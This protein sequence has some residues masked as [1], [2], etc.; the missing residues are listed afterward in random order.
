MIDMSSLGTSREMVLASSIPVYK[1]PPV[2]PEFERKPSLVTR[3]CSWACCFF[4]KFVSHVP[5]A[6]RTPPHRFVAVPVARGFLS[7]SIGADINGVV[8]MLHQQNYFTGSPSV[9]KKRIEELLVSEGTA[10]G[11]VLS[12]LVY[13]RTPPKS[14]EDEIR[15]ISLLSA[16]E[17]VKRCGEHEVYEVENKE[18]ATQESMDRFLA[19][20][21]RAL[22]LGYNDFR[23]QG[24]G[25]NLQAMAALFKESGLECERQALLLDR[26]E[27]EKRRIAEGYEKLTEAVTRYETTYF[28]KEAHVEIERLQRLLKSQTDI[29]S[30][31]VQTTEPLYFRFLI[32]KKGVVKESFSAFVEESRSFIYVPKKGKF[33]FYKKQGCY[34][35]IQKL[36]A[37]KCTSDEYVEMT[38]WKERSRREAESSSGAPS[39]SESPVSAAESDQRDRPVLMLAPRAA[40]AGPSEMVPLLQS[41]ED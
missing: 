16:Y 19:N 13:A 38:V 3:V 31:Y 23:L 9:T 32:I 11:E 26:D 6:R 28:P 39:P 20:K 40:E 41:H 8:D 4:S 29:I 18:R 21:M 2:E 14:E 27:E 35:E 1:L 24:R 37:S 7:T 10:T 30:S 5:S 15:F 12:E 22:S 25:S 33:W 17:K 34:D 36:L